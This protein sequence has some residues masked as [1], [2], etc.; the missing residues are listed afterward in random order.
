MKIFEII[1]IYL[2]QKKV[3]FRLLQLLMVSNI[4][5]TLCN[6]MKMILNKMK[7]FI[8]MKALYK[9]KHKN[10]NRMKIMWRLKQ[11]KN[12]KMKLTNKM[13]NLILLLNFQIMNNKN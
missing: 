9:R 4:I 11:T 3:Y 7:I 6:K 5:Y 2:F 12:N 8:K 1:I 13:N 10:N